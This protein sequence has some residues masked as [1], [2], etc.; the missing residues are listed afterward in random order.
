MRIIFVATFEFDVTTVPSESTLRGLLP[1]SVA[2]PALAPYFPSANPS[3]SWEPSSDMGFDEDVAVVT[4][5]RSRRSCL[6][7][8]V[9]EPTSS[10][11]DLAE[12]LR[13]FRR[14]VDCLSSAISLTRS[15]LEWERFIFWRWN[16]LLQF[17]GV[18][19]EDSDIGGGDLVGIMMDWVCCG[20]VSN[21]CCD[22]LPFRACDVLEELPP[23][24]AFIIDPDPLLRDDV[25]AGIIRPPRDMSWMLCNAA[26]ASLCISSIVLPCDRRLM[27]ALI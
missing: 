20:V 12:S 22:V 2:D 6:E 19:D 16:L 17:C 26:S 11:S 3:A 23:T 21:D 5:L 13:R 24:L 9:E 7:I 18:D 25:D 27:F 15:L 8:N 14:F 1:A 10:S 4:E